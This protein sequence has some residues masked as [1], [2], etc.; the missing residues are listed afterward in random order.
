MSYYITLHYI[1][2]SFEGC[3]SQLGFC[4]YSLLTHNPCQL[5]KQWRRLALELTSAWR[6]SST[7]SVATRAWD[8]TWWCWWQPSEPWKCTGED[9]RWVTLQFLNK[10]SIKLNGYITGT[11]IFTWWGTFPPTISHRVFVIRH[12]VCH[13]PLNTEHNISIYTMNIS[14]VQNKV[15]LPFGKDNSLLG[16]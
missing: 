12:D 6:S 3:N 4:Y 10:Y 11:H 8:P 14:S 7:S 15:S 2:I 5:C 9:Q 13:S 1:I 16:V